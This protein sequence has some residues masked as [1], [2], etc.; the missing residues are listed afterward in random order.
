MRELRD[1]IIA[2]KSGT[3]AMH[4]L[5]GRNGDYCNRYGRCL[6]AP[7]CIRGETVLTRRMYDQRKDV[8][9]LDHE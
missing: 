6:Y 1:K 3:R 7:L 9:D 5:F 2:V 4:E 8:Y